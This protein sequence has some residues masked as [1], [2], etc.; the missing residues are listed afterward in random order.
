[1][2]VCYVDNPTSW[3]VYGHIS[4][5][6]AYIIAIS[7]A[8]MMVGLWHGNSLFLATHILALKVSI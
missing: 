7:V 5:V 4:S 6:S 8:I 3:G 1:M 2:K